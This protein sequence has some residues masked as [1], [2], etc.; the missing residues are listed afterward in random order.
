MV[1]RNE[2]F[3][4]RKTKNLLFEERSDEFKFFP[5]QKT[6]QNNLKSIYSDGRES[7]KF[8]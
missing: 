4:V 8:S 5:N 1:Y 3:E 7:P 6:E 2:V